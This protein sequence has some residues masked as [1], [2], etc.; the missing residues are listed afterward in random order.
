MNGMTDLLLTKIKGLLISRRSRYHPSYSASTTN[1]SQMNIYALPTNIIYDPSPIR[2]KECGE[3]KWIGTQ[4]TENYIA[5]DWI[6][7]PTEKK[8]PS[9]QRSPSD[10]TITESATGNTGLCHDSEVQGRGQLV[11]WALEGF[12]SMLHQIY[13]GNGSLG[14]GPRPSPEAEASKKSSWL[15][16]HLL[17]VS[18]KAII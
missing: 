11:N 5:E 15:K 8:L 17:L 4:Y 3:W 1:Y 2:K 16:N 18:N 6:G 10:N 12:Y 7:P 14:S 13:F 9:I